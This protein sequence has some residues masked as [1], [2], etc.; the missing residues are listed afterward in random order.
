MIGVHRYRNITMQKV[1]VMLRALQNNG[2][3]ISGDNPWEVDTHQSGV[4]LRGQ[5]NEAA[6]NIEITVVDRNWYVSCS[7]VWQQI[8]ELMHRIQALPDVEMRRDKT[9][10]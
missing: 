9:E 4:K 8:D 3:A 5:L 6:S 7:M 1:D 10:K 2:A